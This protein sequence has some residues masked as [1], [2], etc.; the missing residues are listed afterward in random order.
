[1]SALLFGI[2]SLTLILVLFLLFDSVTHQTKLKFL[3]RPVHI[4]N[5]KPPAEQT[6][7][8]GTSDKTGKMFNLQYIICINLFA[9]IKYYSDPIPGKT[10]NQTDSQSAGTGTTTKGSRFFLSLTIGNLL[11]C[12]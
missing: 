6:H 8:D 2:Y 11:R 4:G 1:M 10:H 7:N 9:N 3:S 12:S 5:R